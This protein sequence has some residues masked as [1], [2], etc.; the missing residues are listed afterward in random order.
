VLICYLSGKIYI[1]ATDRRVGHL[2]STVLQTG[3]LVR[4]APGHHQLVII[5]ENQNFVIFA[6]LKSMQ[7]GQSAFIDSG[8]SNGIDLVISIVRFRAGLPTL[9]GPSTELVYA[10]SWFMGNSSPGTMISGAGGDP[11]NRPEPYVPR[12]EAPWPYSGAELR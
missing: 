1:H 6:R 9:T 2:Q 3:T 10:A 7:A 4:T 12:G 5:M 11:L 8:H